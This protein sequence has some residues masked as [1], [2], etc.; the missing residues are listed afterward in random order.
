[1]HVLTKSMLFKRLALTVV[2]AS[3]LVGMFYVRP[4]HAASPINYTIREG[5]TLYLLSQRFGTTVEGIT[6]MNPKVVPENLIIGSRLK[7]MPAPVLTLYTVKRGDTLWKISVKFGVPLDVIIKHN[8]LKYPDVLYPGE[9]LVIPRMK[10]V[11][12]YFIKD[13]ENNFYLVPE[14]RRVSME[15]N[16]YKNTLE[17]LIKGS[18]TTPNAFCSIPRTTAVYGVSVDK[19]IAYPNFSADLYNANVGSATE[20]LTLSAIADTLTEFKEI[21]G[22]FPLVEGKP[23]GS[24]GGHIE[25]TEPMRRNERVI[26]R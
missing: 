22:V 14:T 13:I 25:I 21:T 20:A 18:V 1:M 8:A 5:D 9:I 15:G 16:I 23:M 4:G 6:S 24:L 10:T 17:K 3:L 26:R 19:G 7:I 12:L 11:I 2:C